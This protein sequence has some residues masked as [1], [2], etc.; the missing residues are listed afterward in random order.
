M[1]RPPLI[2]LAKSEETPTSRLSDLGRRCACNPVP[3]P[4][5]QLRGSMSLLVCTVCAGLRAK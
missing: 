4:T 3:P 1:N 2:P 5:R